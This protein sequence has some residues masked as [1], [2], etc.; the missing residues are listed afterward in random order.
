MEVNVSSIDEAFVK[1]Y[2]D[3][4]LGCADQLPAGRMRDAVALR[5]DHVMDLVKAWRE[6]KAKEA[7]G[8]RTDETTQ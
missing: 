4:L 1:R 8:C 5:A 7:L 2:V 3:T 6:H